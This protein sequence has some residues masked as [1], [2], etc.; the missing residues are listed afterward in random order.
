MEKTLKTRFILNRIAGQNSFVWIEFLF[1][2]LLSSKGEEDLL[3][4]NP[5]LST[6]TLAALFSLVMLSMLKANRLGHTNRCIGTVIGL[7]SLLEKVF[8]FVIFYSFFLVLYFY[9]WCCFLVFL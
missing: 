4:L 2:S 7:E 5:Y 9:V 8:Y 1:G 6:N 3:R